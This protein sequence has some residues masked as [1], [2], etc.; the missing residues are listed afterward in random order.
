MIVFLQKHITRA[1]VIGS[2]KRTDIWSYPVVAVRE[3][4]MNAILHA[5]YAQR[6][7]PIRV[8]LFDDRL[9]VENPRLPPFGLT[10]HDI[11]R[12]ISKLRNRFI[13]RVFQESGLIEQWGSGIQRMTAACRDRGLDAPRFEEIGTHF[14]VTLSAVVRGAPARDTRD[15]RIVTALAKH[16]NAGLSTSQIAERIAL[17]SR[18]TRTR[19]SS[20]VERGLIAEIGSGP[21]DHL[22]KR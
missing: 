5:D 10:I 2:V 13:G 15:E 6:G 22:S 16:P 4:V 3:A 7:A 1:A 12:G 8:A 21:K 9:E 11:Q 18:A 20:L 14:R 17:S 19:L